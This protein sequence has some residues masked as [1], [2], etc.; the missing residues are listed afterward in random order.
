MLTERQRQATVC[1]ASNSKKIVREMQK[2]QTSKIVTSK[3]NV[4]CVLK[5]CKHLKR[6]KL[7]HQ[8]PLTSQRKEKRL[9][10]AKSHIQ[11]KK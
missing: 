5:D 4:L 10:F 11:W 9:E 2:Q 8:S 1:K 7:K 3:K 6:L